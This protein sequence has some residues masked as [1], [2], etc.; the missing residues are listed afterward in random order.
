MSTIFPARSLMRQRV[1]IHRL[2]GRIGAVIGGVDLGTGLAEELVAEI[3]DALLAHKVLFFR[4]Q[5]L[6]DSDQ[7]EFASRFGTLTAAHPTVESVP[8]EP[9]VFE[10]DSL[11]G[12]R[13]NYWHTDVTFTDRPPAASVLRAVSLPAFGGDT[14]WANTVSAYEQLPEHLRSIVGGLRAIHTNDFDYGRRLAREAEAAGRKTQQFTSTIFETEH[15]VVRVHPDTGERSI[16]LGGFA[17]HVVGLSTIDSADLIRTIQSHVT[18]P[19]NTVSWRWQPGDVAMWDNRATQHYAVDDYGDEHRT[20][21]RVT[22]AGPVPVGI[23]GR[24]SVATVGDAS[25]YSSAA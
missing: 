15:P 7:L 25:A 24:A 19:E 3:R 13:A 5:H 21:R 23:D 1:E 2:S 20:V 10:L 11:D 4:A 8:D 16:L 17:K 9:H 14:I 18:K 6:A 12:G 22:I